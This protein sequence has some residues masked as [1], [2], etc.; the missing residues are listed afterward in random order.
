MCLPARGQA[1]NR[2]WIQNNFWCVKIRVC[3]QHD[4]DECHSDAGAGARGGL[5]VTKCIRFSK[6]YADTT[7]VVELIL[8]LIT[9]TPT[10]P[11]SLLTGR[12]RWIRFV[13]SDGA[14]DPRLDS[15][16][17]FVL[18]LLHCQLQLS[19]RGTMRREELGRGLGGLLT[20]WEKINWTAPI[21]P[22]PPP[23]D[24]SSAFDRTPVLR[25]SPPPFLSPFSLPII[26][27]SRSPR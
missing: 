20:E 14:V 22:L 8:E 12:P 27:L 6:S 19:H 15:E 16:L 7:P 25:S 11:L 3:K 9:L 26:P 1:E 21:T 17:V 13:A 18:P 23:H 2:I 4:D 24:S 5:D 10:P